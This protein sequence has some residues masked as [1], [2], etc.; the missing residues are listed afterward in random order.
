MAAWI[1]GALIV[2]FGWAWICR[3][4]LDNPREDFSAGVVWHGMRI[5]SRVLQLLRVVGAEHISQDRH[6]GP[7]I[8]VCNHTAGIDPILVQALCPFEVRFVMAQDMRHPMLEWFWQLSGVIFV[9]REAGDAMGAREAIRHHKI[10]GLVH[11]PPPS[12]PC[13]GNS[14]GLPGRASRQMDL[15]RD[16]RAQVSP[17]R[18]AVVDDEPSSGTL[19][20]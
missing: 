8:V 16:R 17:P 14:L 15:S 5:Y 19:I 7:L 9:D 20:H 11:A 10:Q 12:Q 3:R 1:I 6:P 18:K 2:L 13:A 4:L